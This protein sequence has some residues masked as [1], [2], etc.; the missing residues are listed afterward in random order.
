MELNKNC[1]GDYLLRIEHVLEI[2]CISRATLYKCI[3]AG[4]FPAPIKI[5]A[6]SR[7]RNSDIQK[8]IKKGAAYE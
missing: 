8:L 1:L 5:G 4:H 6:A 2:L 7:W 3:Q